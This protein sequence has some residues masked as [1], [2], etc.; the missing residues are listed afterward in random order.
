MM[1]NAD[2]RQ[3]AYAAISLEQKSHR[4]ERHALSSTLVANHAPERSR[5]VEPALE[6]CDPRAFWRKLPIDGET[7]AG[8]LDRKGQY[9]LRSAA[10][11]GRSLTLAELA[12]VSDRDS[13]P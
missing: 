12:H 5:R 10:E 6:C 11:S 2:P 7:A 1:R 8:P 4:S 13:L 3:A 9:V